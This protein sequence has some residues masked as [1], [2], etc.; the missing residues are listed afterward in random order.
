MTLIDVLDTFVVLDDR[1][2]FEMAVKNVIQWVSFD[3][4]TKPQVFETTI[5][6]LGGLLS[7][8]I[9]ANQ[10]GQP[11]F[12]PW[13]NGELLAL[14]HDLGKRLL[15]AFSTPT[16]LPYARVSVISFIMQRFI[17]G[18]SLKINLRHGL[19]KGETLET[20]KLTFSR[21]R[22]H[23]VERL[24]LWLGTAGAGSLILEFATLSRFTGDERF[25]KA[26]QKAFFGIWNRKSDIGLVGN[27]INTWTGVWSRHHFLLLRLNDLCRHGHPPRLL[28]SGL[29]LILSMNMR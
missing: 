12:L 20:C 27:T 10:T 7:G 14:A 15:P 19:V 1:Q 13:Y 29:V 21:A 26:A 18:V 6:V 9:F 24:F 23:C 17:H 2:G 3:V 8:H 4:D 16:G 11:F 25:E 22:N 5:R 28:A